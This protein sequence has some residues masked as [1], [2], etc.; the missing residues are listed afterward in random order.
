M[1]NFKALSVLFAMTLSAPALALPIN[2][3]GGTGD[4][5]I[6]KCVTDSSGTLSASPSSVPLGGSTTLSWSVTFPTGC[7]NTALWLDGQ[8]VGRNGSLVVTPGA[9]STRSLRVV[10]G[11][12]ERVLAST[13]VWV[14]LPPVVNITSNNQVPLFVQAVST[15][16]TTIVIANGVSLD[17]SNRQDIPVASNVTIRGGRGGMQDG[18]LI[19]TTTRPEV[20]FSISPAVS[21]V[22]VTGVRVAGPDLGVPDRYHNRAFSV[23]SA[24]H[25]EFDHNEI[26]GFSG[27]GIEVIDN[28]NV[29]PSPDPNNA[30][31]ISF[32]PV[33]IHDNYIHNNEATGGDGYGVVVS[34]GAHPLIDR[35]VFD[36]NR[37]SIAGDGR[38]GS[39]YTAVDNLVLSNGGLHRWIPFPGFWIHTHQFDMHGRDNCGV[40]DLVSDTLYNCGPAG[41]TM[42]IRRNTFFYHEDNDIKLRGT[43][44]TGMFVG[45]NVFAHFGSFG[46][47][48]DQTETGLHDEGTNS[49]DYDGSAKLGSCDFDGDGIEDSFMATGA[50]WWYAPGGNKMWQ[51]L[52]TSTKKLDE[53]SLGDFDGDHKCDVSVG[54]VIY[55]GGRQPNPRLQPRPTIGGVFTIN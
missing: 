36:W 14:V 5:P 37:H 28:Q 42:I 10:V 8:T 40:W 44:T 50:T 33:R 3:G 54:G 20:L 25:I 24:T 17:L 23:D 41:D 4:P 2:T 29:M 19:F 11:S 45:G 12:A 32:Y 39:G 48:A 15:A 31:V 52:N 47:A 9:N 51:Y 38:P 43:P 30:D 18:P 46:D 22:R 16:G 26:Y 55:P 34:T 35:N 7:T 21:N 27:S 53:V 49:Y 13:P 1:E 6:S